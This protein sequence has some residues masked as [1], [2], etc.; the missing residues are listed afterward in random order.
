MPEL[1][2][3][4]GALPSTATA[5]VLDDGA[6]RRRVPT[7]WADRSGGSDG[8]HRDEVSMRR[9][10]YACSGRHNRSA[11]VAGTLRDLLFFF[12]KKKQVR[13]LNCDEGMCHNDGVL[14]ST[15]KCSKC[16]G[17]CFFF[18]PDLCIHGTTTVRPKKNPQN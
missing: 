8:R 7:A 18:N 3:Q 13:C 17:E 11:F 10:L 9:R 14:Y 2:A 6:C 12:L 5:R 4:D 15:T 1:H 16:L